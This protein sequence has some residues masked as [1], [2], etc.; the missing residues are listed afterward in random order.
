MSRNSHQNGADDQSESCCPTELE[1]NKMICQPAL[2]C[3]RRKTRHGEFDESMEEP[4]HDERKRKRYKESAE[5][6][7]SIVTGG[8]QANE[9]EEVWGERSEQQSRRHKT[10][11]SKRESGGAMCECEWHAYIMRQTAAVR[12]VRFPGVLKKPHG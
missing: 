12:V 1:F 9:I 11:A 4:K 6:C 3:G 10:E 5:Q 7:V 8:L 2:N